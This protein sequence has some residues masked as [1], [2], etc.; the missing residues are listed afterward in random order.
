MKFLESRDSGFYTMSTVQYVKEYQEI[1][2]RKQYVEIVECQL[3]LINKPPFY[4]YQIL[5]KVCIMNII[6]NT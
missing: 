2:E 4:N 6:M 3:K 1:L 5:M